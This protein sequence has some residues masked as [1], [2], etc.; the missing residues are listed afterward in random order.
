MKFFNKSIKKNK[1]IDLNKIYNELK[2]L[3]KKTR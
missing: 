1:K 2:F 3:I